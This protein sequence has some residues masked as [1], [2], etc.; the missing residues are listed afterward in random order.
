MAK[1]SAT[2][3]FASATVNGRR[4]KTTAESAS[5]TLSTTTDSI[6][7]VGINT[8][9]DNIF[10]DIVIGVDPVTLYT[11]GTAA[12]GGVCTFTFDATASTTSGTPNGKYITLT[13][14][15]G[16]TRTYTIKDNLKATC[17]DGLSLAGV[18]GSSVNEGCN[19]TNLTTAAGCEA[20]T[21]TILLDEDQTVGTVDAAANQICIGVSGVASDALLTDLIIKAI[22]GTTDSRI[23][24]ATSGNGTTGVTGITATE[25]SSATQITLTMDQRGT[26]GNIAT[27]LTEIAGGAD[28]VA[29]VG[30]TGGSGTD[31]GTVSKNEFEPGT[32]ASLTASNLLAAIEDTTHGHKD[33]RFTVA[34]GPGAGVISITQVTTGTAGN[35]AIATD[36]NDICS[37]NPPSYF[38]NGAAAIRPNL[39]M[40]FSH[41][42]TDWTKGVI[43]SDDV[44]LDTG[45]VYLTHYDFS[46]YSAPYA[47]IVINEN[48]AVIGTSGTHQAFYAY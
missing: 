17:V 14:A 32:T 5:V 48:N 4:V 40:Q 23:A 1:Q 29:V 31:G 2:E 19:F 25:G 8:A 13:S 6:T 33:T 47:R 16:E 42:G 24:F 10:K 36:F 18:N 27:V 38:L 22:N 26:A 9:T 30:F 43:L 21:T 15:D 44:E 28:M 35:T 46:S 34:L 11:N 20:G 39:T 41:N 3:S 37:V 12:V 45:A 7:H